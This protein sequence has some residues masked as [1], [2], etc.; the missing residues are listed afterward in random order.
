MWKDRDRNRE[1]ETDRRGKS[2]DREARRPEDRDREGGNDD[3]GLT[4]TGLAGGGRKTYVSLTYPNPRQHWWWERRGGGVGGG[5]E[6][7]RKTFRRC[8]FCHQHFRD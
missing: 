6:E 7:V 8:Q 3:G 1:N 5:E 4:V 2:T